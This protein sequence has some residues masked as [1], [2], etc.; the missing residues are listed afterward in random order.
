MMQDPDWIELSQE[1]D[2]MFQVTL[3]TIRLSIPGF[4]PR[5]VPDPGSIEEVRPIPA[6]DVSEEPAAVEV[7]PP[8]LVKLISPP[9]P[10]AGSVDHGEGVS[11]SN[12]RERFNSGAEATEPVLVAQRAAAAREVVH[13]VRQEVPEAPVESAQVF[14]S[15]SSTSGKKGKIITS[16]PA[17]RVGSSPSGPL[18]FGF[19]EEKQQRKSS[20][21]TSSSVTSKVQN[22]EKS[23]TNVSSPLSVKDRVQQLMKKNNNPKSPSVGEATSSVASKEWTFKKNKVSAAMQP[24]LKNPAPAGII[25]FIKSVND[26]NQEND[27]NHDVNDDNNHDVEDEEMMSSSSHSLSSLLLKM[28]SDRDESRQHKPV[29]VARKK[30]KEIFFA[31]AYYFRYMHTR[32]RL[33]QGVYLVK[34]QEAKPGRVSQ[35]FV[36]I[37]LE[38]NSL[39]WDSKGHVTNLPLSDLLW[40]EYGT[41]SRCFEKISNSISSSSKEANAVVLPWNCLTLVFKGRTLNVYSDRKAR[42]EVDLKTGKNKVVRVERVAKPFDTSREVDMLLFFLSIYFSESKAMTRKISGL[43]RSYAH[44]RWARSLI[45]LEYTSKSNKMSS[46]LQT[47]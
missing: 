7:F 10:A 21:A 8:P 35:C 39:W 41:R 1:W 40:V 27:N 36:G 16:P 12:L 47:L 29:I 11:V 24:F 43:F 5:L 28:P 13:L 30:V 15:P 38:K 26:N 20:R 33:A 45:K 9:P 3:P 6:L 17:S 2:R 31:A 22:D 23:E 18:R 34:L 46:F 14:S 32:R 19:E 4:P 42:G 44:L 25:P 37:D